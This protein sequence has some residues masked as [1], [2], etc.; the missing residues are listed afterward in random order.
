M[1]HWNTCCSGIP[2]D[3]QQCLHIANVV[4]TDLLS[5]SLYHQ[6]SIFCPMEAKDYTQDGTVDLHGQPV[7]ASKTGKWKACAFLVGILLL[8]H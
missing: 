4:A 3:K 5:S 8:S 6:P 2:S 7:L 1:W